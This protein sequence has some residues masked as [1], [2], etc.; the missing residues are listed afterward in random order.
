MDALIEHVE[1]KKR[2]VFY[3]S[4]PMPNKFVKMLSGVKIKRI[5]KK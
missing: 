4:L 3:N 1:N 2:E 5:Y